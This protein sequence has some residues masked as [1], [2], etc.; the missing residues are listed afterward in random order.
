MLLLVERNAGSWQAGR[1][2]GAR[3]QATSGCDTV[4]EALTDTAATTSAIQSVHDGKIELTSALQRTWR[5]P[6]SSKPSHDFRFPPE[7]EVRMWSTEPI[8]AD[9]PVMVL[10]L[11]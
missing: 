11:C 7:V 3:R 4:D 1:P 6:T 8:S 9:I 2:P 10:V 5:Q